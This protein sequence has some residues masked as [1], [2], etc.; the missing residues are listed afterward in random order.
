[1]VMITSTASS[2]AALAGSMLVLLATGPSSVQAQG[3]SCISLNSSSMCPSFAGQY[4]DPTGLTPA[5]PFFAD[6][7]D[8]ASFDTQFANYY[9]EYE[10]FRQTQLHSGLQ[11]NQSGFLNATLQW[12]QTVLCG[13]FTATSD[14]L[15]CTP[16]NNAAMTK[17]CQSTCTQ[18]SQSEYAFVA[19]ASYC[20][21]TADLTDP[22]WAVTRNNTLT[23]DYQSCTDWSSIYTANDTSCVLG[24]SNEGN[25]GFGDGPN[26][27]LCG[28]CDLA[29]KS[30]VPSCCYEDKTDLSGCAAFGYP[31]AAV[32]KPTFSVPAGTTSQNG[33]VAGMS[34]GGNGLSKGALAGIIIGSI[35]G[36]L[37]LLALLGLLIW[38]CCCGGRRKRKQREPENE[39]AVAGAPRAASSSSPSEKPYHASQDSARS[40]NLSQDKGGLAAGAL[41]GAAL[42]AAA[43]S[44]KH[45]PTQDPSAPGTGSDSRP[46]STATSGTDGRGATVSSV[47][48][49]YTGQDIAPGDTVVAI[50]PYSAGLSDELDLTPESREEL[51][52]V[53]IYDDGWCLLRT[54]SGKEGAAPLVCCQS[55]K[56]E[57]PA[58][59]RHGSSGAFDSSGGTTSGNTDD[60]T[61]GSRSGGLGMRAPP[62]MSS[63]NTDG[64]QTAGGY[65]S[66][67]GYQTAGGGYGGGTTSGA[68]GGMASSAGGAV[69]ADEY[70]FTS[71]A[72]SR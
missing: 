55:S 7:T 11:C 63:S 68:E 49:Q 64:Y 22:A 38:C 40:R 56:G 8:V 41:G 25:C 72:A 5:Y 14:N 50:Y 46:L 13:I 30:S 43:A 9:T 2:L 29:S 18:Y 53:R 28:Y 36:G 69:T 47:R 19:N 44:G 1:M 48:C 60:E 61:S 27:Q 16:D 20:T 59:M 24:V 33:A 4:V 6:V 71:D 26:A 23:S 70:G 31:A 17:V 67:G 34:S 32:I 37:L 3:T 12:S 51:S 15:G 42:G 39:A 65:T 35:I 45:S 54:P 58:H 52:V 57:L 10:Q 21:P 66:G 62:N